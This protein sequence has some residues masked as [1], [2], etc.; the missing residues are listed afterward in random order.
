MPIPDR[1]VDLYL[2]VSRS[3]EGVAS[4]ARRGVPLIKK[5]VALDAL[6]F[7]VNEENPIDGLTTE[8]AR[9]VYRGAITNWKEVG[10]LDERIFPFQHDEGTDSQA[11]MEDL[12][13]GGEP[14]I[15][16]RWYEEAFALPEDLGAPMMRAIGRDGLGYTLRGVLGTI[17]RNENY[18]TLKIDGVAPTDDAIRKG[19]YPLTV[20]LYGIIRA[21]DADKTGGRFLDWV[22]SD[23]GQDC[24]RGAGY[25]PVS[26]R[27]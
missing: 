26:E 16:E 8:Q 3:V 4:P 2:G 25:L 18:K 24:V 9:G 22:L 23:E 6:V 5:T 13:M 15:D 19:S 20:E 10:G 12:V 14:L 1:P 21:E 11:V 7:V 27:N 17:H